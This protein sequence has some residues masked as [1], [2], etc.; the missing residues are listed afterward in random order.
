MFDFTSHIW[1][2]SLLFEKEVYF[3]KECICEIILYPAVILLLHSLSTPYVI[4]TI[5]WIRNG[6]DDLWTLNKIFSRYSKKGHWCTCKFFLLFFFFPLATVSAVFE[7]TCGDPSLPG[8][9]F[10]LKQSGFLSCDLHPSHSLRVL[11]KVL[12]IPRE[13]LYGLHLFNI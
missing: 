11:L 5:M 6:Q 3:I 2:A 9:H 12:E 13:D 1:G 10:P 4:H 8:S 7:L